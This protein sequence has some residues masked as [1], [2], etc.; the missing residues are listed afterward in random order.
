MKRAMLVVLVLCLCLAT[1]GAQ[2]L[3]GGVGLGLRIGGATRQ[4]SGLLLG[5]DVGVPGL[6]FFKGLKS[7]V[8]VDTWG[9]PTSGWDRSNGGTAVAFM[10][11]ADGVVGYVG[12]GAGYSR[13][14]LHGASYEGPEL[15]LAAGANVLGLG[16]EANYHVGKI[17]T[18]TGMVRFR[19]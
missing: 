17:A 18:W 4:T 6:S 11:M 2:A 8:D 5:L 19:F 15:K 3:P 13:L 9:Q 10:Q 1:R 14:R 12:I 16:L 7:R